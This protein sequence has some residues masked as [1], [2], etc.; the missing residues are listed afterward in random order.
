M[1]FKIN[2]T[3]A[4]RKLFPEL[5]GA[6]VSLPEETIEVTYQVT[7]LISINAGR[8]WVQ[9]TISFEGMNANG[10]NV[11]ECEYSG[12]GDILAEA[13]TKLLEFLQTEE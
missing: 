9:Y 8:I 1:S 11:F 3:V 10:T 4:P 6:F 13:E 12:S 2:R 7:D 5:G